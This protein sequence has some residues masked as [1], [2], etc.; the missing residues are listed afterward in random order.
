V[1]GGFVWLEISM[2][3]QMC[4]VIE[5]SQAANGILQGGQLCLCR[6]REFKITQ[7]GDANRAFQWRIFL[8]YSANQV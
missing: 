3:R 1:G 5:I 8:L 6:L 7:E 4:D 2:A